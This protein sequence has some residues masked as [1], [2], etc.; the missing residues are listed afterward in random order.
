MVLSLVGRPCC[1]SATSTAALNSGTGKGGP[2][3]YMGYPLPRAP[4]SVGRMPCGQG[5]PPLRPDGAGQ[6][7]RVK[8][9]DAE[10]DDDVEEDR[11]LNSS[12]SDSSDFGRQ[13]KRKSGFK[14][15]ANTYSLDQWRSMRQ[16]DPPKEIKVKSEEEDDRLP[17]WDTPS[18]KPKGDCETSISA[19]KKTVSSLTEPPESAPFRSL[20]FPHV[21][22][23]RR[24]GPS[25]QEHFQG[26]GPA[27]GRRRRMQPRLHPLWR[28]RLCYSGEE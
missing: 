4:G 16:V 10:D 5:S 12:Y 13:P 20:K 3:S 28:D 26:R 21:P 18:T 11:E 25:G 8:D 19:L 22:S 9:V 17:K 15:A 6:L 7:R 24:G 23:P 2:A 14:L 1:C 27:D